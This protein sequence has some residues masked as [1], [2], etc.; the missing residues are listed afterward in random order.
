MEAQATESTFEAMYALHV[1]DVLA[2]CRRRTGWAEAHDATADVFVVAWRRMAELPE[3]S[4]VLPWLYGVAAN[5]LRNQNRTTRRARN[6]LSKIG[7]NPRRYQPG[8]EVQVVRLEEYEEVRQAIESLD[9]KYRE[10]V[11]LVVWE[12]LPREQ[13]AELMSVS[14]A[15]I[16]QRLHR[17]YEQLERR[18]DPRGTAFLAKGVVHDTE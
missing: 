17:A 14:R 16:D 11:K 18:L 13:V 7:S 12:G 8:P 3:D 5:V 4:E 10:V 1:R 9:P 15:A 2:Y 6:L